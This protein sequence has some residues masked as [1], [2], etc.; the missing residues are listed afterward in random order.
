MM[1]L[2]TYQHTLEMS[3]E[4]RDRVE[5]MDRGSMLVTWKL[6]D[7]DN[8]KNV[9]YV[10]IWTKLLSLSTP[11]CMCMYVRNACLFCIGGSFKLAIGR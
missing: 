4:E 8:L 7:L 10:C 3:R 6:D 2:I 5:D 1:N 11:V 9:Y